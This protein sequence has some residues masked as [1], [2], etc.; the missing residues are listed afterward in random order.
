MKEKAKKLPASFFQDPCNR[1]WWI[2]QIVSLRK[3]PQNFDNLALFLFEF[4]KNHCAVYKTFCQCFPQDI[5]SWRDIPALPQELF[6]KTTVFCHDINK[7]GFYYLSSGTTS[8]ARGKHNFLDNTVY[9]AISVLG[10]VQAEIPIDQ[11]HLHFLVPSSKEEPHSS[12]SAMFSF[13]AEKNPFPS[14]FWIKNNVL[15]T[16]SFRQTLTEQ[17]IANRK[18]GVCG[19]AFSFAYLMDNE[20]NDP[21]ILPQGSFILETGGMKGKH[22][23]VDRKEFYLRLSSYFGLPQDQIV[24]EYGMTELST[25]AYSRGYD[26]EF[27]LPP[28]ARV[29][30][31]DPRTDQ[32]CQV[33]QRGL[34]R[35]ID[36]ANVDSVL[37]IQTLD[38]GIRTPK[39]FF[40]L[41]RS[42]KATPRGCSLSFEEMSS[43]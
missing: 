33:G 39:S 18:V 23:E 34:I 24:S 42:I 19:T 3:N 12:L 10:A 43:F 32:E 5:S 13:W 31:I 30:I 37:C 25:Q 11:V 6:K 15:Q 1:R 22:R 35:W 27:Q 17:I 14:H 20:P 7:A 16:K 40:L 29:L 4:Q 21:M 38:I 41:G 28:W 26:G 9:K 8:G 2:D 36:L